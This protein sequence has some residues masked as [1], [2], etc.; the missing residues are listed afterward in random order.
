MNESTNTSVLRKGEKFNVSGIP[1]PKLTERTR[2]RYQRISHFYDL[3]EVLPEY[4]YHVWRKV[5]W[6]LITGPRVLEVGIGTGKNLP[7]YP[8]GMQVIG[9]DITPGMLSRAKQKADE[10]NVDVD[11]QLGDVQAL[12]FPD[13]TF[14]AIAATFV[15]CSVPDPILGLSELL[16]V[17]KP[18]GQL[19]FM[20]HIRADNP[21][22]GTLMDVL[23]PMVV[24]MMGA[25]INRRTPEN[26]REAGLI[27]DHVEDLKGGGGIF[28]LIIAHRSEL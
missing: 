10:L 2:K 1:D 14:D 25:N 4:K 19:L 24:R 13:G 7:Y 11:L 28:K 27:V 5:F 8:E 15:F 16:R 3:M 22:L 17:T 18:G 21:I 23:N 6:H 12:P 20:E 9:I 26:I